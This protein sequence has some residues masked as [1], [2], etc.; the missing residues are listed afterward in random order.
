MPHFAQVDGTDVVIRV[1]VADQ[2]FID[3]G[4]VG[5]PATWIETD[6]ESYAGKSW[7]H[8]TGQEKPGKPS[9]EI[10]YAGPGMKYNRA[11]KGFEGI[12]PFPSWVMDNVTLLYKP[13]KARPP[14]QNGNPKTWVWDE[15][16]EDWILQ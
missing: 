2:A 3:S 5:D 11:Q 15:A 13:P 9:K 14:H 10:N 8:A 4:R 16:T 6:P 1:I 12:K 7:D